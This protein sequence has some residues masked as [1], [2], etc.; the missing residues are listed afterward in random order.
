MPSAAEIAEVIPGSEL[1]GDGCVVSHVASLSTADIG[2]LVWRRAGMAPL[3]SWAGSVMIACR[4]S[5][6]VRSLDQAVVYCENPRLGLALA[7]QRFWPKTSALINQ[8]HTARVDDTAIIGQQGNSVEWD[9]ERL[10]RI[11]PQA[12]VIIH[13]RVYIGAYTTV[14]RGMLED[15]VIGEGTEICNHV[16]VGHGVVIGSHCI[17]APFVALGGSAKIGNR[18]TIWQGARIRNGV[19]IGDGATIGQAANVVGDVEAGMTMV[20]NPARRLD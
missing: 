9:G 10:Q 5:L 12:G 2:D 20:G 6:I 19:K 16:N 3:S 14:V 7:L 11:P 15:T 17:I 4:G 1:V 8:H 18:V 13:E